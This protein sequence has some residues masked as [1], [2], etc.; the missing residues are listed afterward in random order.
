MKEKAVFVFVPTG[1]SNVPTT[2][3]LQMT[4]VPGVTNCGVH[5]PNVLVVPTTP[6]PLVVSLKVL[7][8]V[9]KYIGLCRL[10]MK[11]M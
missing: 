3:A 9:G 6:M 7:V 5:V 4:C 11:V 8:E 1:G 10:F 2:F